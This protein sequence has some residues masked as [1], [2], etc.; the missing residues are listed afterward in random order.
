MQKSQLDQITSL[1]TTS[2]LAGSNYRPKTTSYVINNN[3]SDCLVK[4]KYGK[5]LQTAL[6]Q[7]SYVVFLFSK[8]GVDP[9]YLPRC[10]TVCTT[11]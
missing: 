10:T 11:D 3:L 8:R 2:Y 7:Q 9:R 4:S 6:Y 1:K 5:V